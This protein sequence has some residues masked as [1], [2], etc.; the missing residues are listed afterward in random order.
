MQLSSWP[1]LSCFPF[2]E[3]RTRYAALQPILGD[4]RGGFFP[5]ASVLL[6]TEK[7]SHWWHSGFIDKKVDYSN[8]R[9]LHTRQAKAAHGKAQTGHVDD[10]P[11]RP[12]KETNSP[13]ALTSAA[14]RT[15]RL[16]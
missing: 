12:Q 7:R 5:T 9:Q 11:A 3:N 2:G 13:P 1:L 10:D 8:V 6:V 15:S 14:T 16:Y 4:S